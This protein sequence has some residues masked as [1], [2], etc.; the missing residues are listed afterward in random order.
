MG[1]HNIKGI[2]FDF[3]GTLTYPG[4][5]NFPAIKRELNCPEDTPILEYLDT[6]PEDR[7]AELL[8]ILELREEQAAEGSLPNKG[9][10]RCI[11][12][13]KN[14]GFALGILTRN[15]RRAVSLALEKFDGIRPEDFAAVITRE[16]SLPKPHPDGLLKILSHFKIVPR[17][18]LY[19][20]D[21]QVDAEA[22]AAAQIPFVAYRNK[23]L[24]APYHI[25]NLK[26]LE[27]LLE[28]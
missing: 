10:E 21:S 24:P 25:E 5:L 6:Q 20:G 28:V 14:K 22:A 13:L 11:S 7:R 4:A 27:A 23:K 26:D 3:D 16:N 15:T 9:A 12:V 1:K 17:Q 2:L 19:V 8:K 18:A